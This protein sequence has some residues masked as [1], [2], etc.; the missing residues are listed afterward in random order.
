VVNASVVGA[1]EAARAFEPRIR[2]LGARFGFEGVLAEDYVDLTA[3]AP[4]AIDRLCR[5][6]GAALGSSRYRPSDEALN[7]ADARLRRR[8]VLGLL[9]VGGNDTAETLHRVHRQARAHNHDLAVVGIPK[10]I[11]NDLACMD[12]APGYGSAA[13]FLAIA[14]REA[15]LDTAAMRRT[16]PVKVIEVMGRNAGWLAA[17]TALAWRLDR[18]PQI[19]FLPERP[20][21]LH[22]MLCEVESV[23]RAHG[24]AVVVI[25]ENQRDD[26]GRP[27]AGEE[28]LYVDP[29][30]HTYFESPGAH[31]ARQI[32]A[33]LGLRA[34]YDRP[35]SLQR[36]WAAE[37]SDV[38]AGEARLVGAAAA[39]RALAGESDLMVTIQR[40]PHHEYAVELSAVQLEEVA[41]QERRLPDAFIGHSGLDVT[42]A[43]L[44]YAAPLIGGPLP[45]VER[46]L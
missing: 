40:A 42:A 27:L 31:L 20:R 10:T 8:G 22:Q 4:D 9:M 28:P 23:H 36:T 11:D 16:D 35:G 5:T 3:L 19:I 30:G 21:S 15:A 39:R 37:M 41:H 7:E 6:P 2:V 32:Q 33:R 45:R 17:A 12:H 43:F 18:G 13:R 1:L 44:E 29:H 26:D 14:A 38:D 25:S 46:L 24:W 34:R